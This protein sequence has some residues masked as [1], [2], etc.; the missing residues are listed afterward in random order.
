M[1]NG[2]PEKRW[3]IQHFVV[4]KQRERQGKVDVKNIEIRTATSTLSVMSN[5]F[6]RFDLAYLTCFRQK[7]RKHQGKMDEN[8]L[9]V[10]PG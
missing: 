10:A 8:K 1:C 2:E 4:R 3:D 7:L 9:K 5:P 6:C